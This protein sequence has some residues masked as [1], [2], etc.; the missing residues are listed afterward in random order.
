MIVVT[1]QPDLE[2]VERES[3]ESEYKDKFSQQRTWYL[4]KFEG[5]N[6]INSGN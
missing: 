2:T 1:L 4:Q 3:R 5:L 6:L